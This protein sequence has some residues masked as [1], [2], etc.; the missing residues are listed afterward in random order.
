MSDETIDLDAI[1]ARERE[2]R[3][4]RY[5]SDPAH[6]L[7]ELLAVIHR[8]GGH[9]VAAHG[10]GRAVEDAVSVVYEARRAASEAQAIIAGRTTPPTDAE[11]AAHARRATVGA[12]LITANDGNRQLVYLWRPFDADSR[13]EDW[14]ML[15][16]R[17]GPFK[18]TIA[19]WVPID[20]EG[21]PCAWPVAEGER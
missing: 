2:A 7:Q 14:E 4:A 21:C 17:M 6:A 12:W 5:Q 9:Y 16:R 8:D 1:E 13:S 10:I 3:I 18:F 11:I 20:A 19:R 15:R